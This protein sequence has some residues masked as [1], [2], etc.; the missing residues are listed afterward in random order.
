[1]STAV[2]HAPA[3]PLPS[4]HMNRDQSPRNCPTLAPAT[5]SSQS[6]LTP[7][8]I[9]HDGS[10]AKSSPSGRKPTSPSSQNG[11]NLP[12][13][14]VKK[15]PPSSPA[16]QTQSRTQTSSRPRPRKLD[17]T[18]SLPNAGGLS[19]R[20]PGGPMTARDGVS[21]HHVGIA[22]LSPGFQTH[23]PIMREQLQRSLSVRDQQRSII[24]SRL[25]KS[26]KDDGPDGVR[27]SESNTFGI[28]KTSSKRRPPPGL[29]IVPP[30]AAQFANERV[31]QSA[32]LNQTFTGRHQAQPLTRH[33]MNQSPTLGSSS[34]I[35]HVPATQT[36]NRLPPLSD[37]FGSDAL[38]SRDR[39]SN[40]GPFYQGA[41]ATNSSQSNNLPPL[42]S[43]RM[44]GSVTQAPSRP[45]E[46][47]S[48]EE[49][50]HELAGGREELLPRI[51][52]YN[53]HQ[54]PTPP[55]PRLGNGQPKSRHSNPETAPLAG[56][57]TPIQPVLHAG[58]GTARRRT[59]TE[60]EQDNGSP[61]LGHGP[62]PHYRPNPALTA[63]TN[64]AYGPFGAGRDSP[65]TQRK[66]KEEF[67]SL[68][69]RAWD[70]FHS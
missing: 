65:E 63:G 1:M 38:G 17:L 56:A 57:H 35:H 26:A 7:P 54:P 24:E 32:P 9:S 11:S 10:T 49:A 21:M 60:Y 6:S 55:S 58:E 30:S 31:I 43:P 46:Y 50:V 52:H 34:H 37:V 42:P 67:L 8:R 3:A 69:A 61:P 20:A 15:E 66:K 22:C 5:T 36:N 29:S 33:V 47:R 45:R 18:T 41:S 59:R 19:A 40:R 12:K 23:D 25:H 28:P 44:P 4:P 27:P 14:I 13:V 2:A 70:L 64:I 53:G 68:C 62:E 16:M 48:A 39:D 51:V